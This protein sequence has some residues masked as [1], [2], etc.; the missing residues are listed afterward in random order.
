MYVHMYVRLYVQCTYMTVI[1]IGMSVTGRC[2]CDRTKISHDFIG[3][4]SHEATTSRFIL[5]L[6]DEV[7]DDNSGWIGSWLALLLL[8]ALV[9]EHA[10][11][12]RIDI[13]CCIPIWG[14]S[15]QKWVLPADGWRWWCCAL[16]GN[17]ARAHCSW[18]LCFYWNG[19]L[20]CSELAWWIHSHINTQMPVRLYVCR[21]I[22]VVDFFRFLFGKQPT[23]PHLECKWAF[24]VRAFRLTQFINKLFRVV[25]PW[26]IVNHS[27]ID[28]LPR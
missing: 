27:F 16:D 14:F 8:P 3:I 24:S 25:F 15:C 4:T 12:I 23:S 19:G 22:C 13:F 9:S 10:M 6:L 11:G 26:N 21:Y 17:T 28:A 20:G 2:E 18:L 7:E 5:A 1:A